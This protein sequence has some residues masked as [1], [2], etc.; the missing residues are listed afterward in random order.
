MVYRVRVRV[1]VRFL[2]GASLL[3]Q[4]GV[5]KLFV[6]GGLQIGAPVF[7]RALGSGAPREPAQTP[8]RKCGPCPRSVA[9]AHGV[10]SRK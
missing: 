6:T 9:R 5:T 3:V 2:G 10:Q 8:R 4:L 1:R 7:S